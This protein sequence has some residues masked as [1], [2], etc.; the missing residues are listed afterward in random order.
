M[1]VCMCVCVYVCMCVCIT[2][3]SDSTVQKN[4]VIQCWVHLFFLTAACVYVFWPLSWYNSIL[5]LREGQKCRQRR[6][7]ESKSYCSCEFIFILLY[8][9]HLQHNKPVHTIIN[10]TQDISAVNIRMDPP[11]IATEGFSSDS[12]SERSPEQHIKNVEK[13]R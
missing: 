3:I 12:L 4:I 2:F 7:G 1:Y 9:V 6:L 5:V 10:V 13:S 8:H 11:Q